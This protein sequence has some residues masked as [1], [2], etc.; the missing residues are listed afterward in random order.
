MFRYFFHYL[1][2][3]SDAVPF[4]IATA[5]QKVLSI[6]FFCTVACVALHPITFLTV[7]YC[8]QGNSFPPSPPTPPELEFLE[9]ESEDSSDEEEEDFIE[10]IN[11]FADDPWNPN[12][13][14]LL[15]ACNICGK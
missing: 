12:F 14:A 10:I 7:A 5:I 15:E 2:L 8:D 6:L 11:P 4:G 1:F 13:H 9:L 3:Y